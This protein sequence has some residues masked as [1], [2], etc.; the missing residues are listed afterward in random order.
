MPDSD[1]SHPRPASGSWTVAIFALVLAAAGFAVYANSLRGPF[2]FDDLRSIP[3]NPSIHHLVTAFSPPGGGVTVTGRPVLNF[4]FALNYALSGTRVWSYHLFNLLIHLAAGL[5][6]FGIVRRTLEN[7]GWDGTEAATDSGAR[8]R[9]SSVAIAFAAGLLWIVHPLQTESVTYV[10]QRAESLMGLFYLL[11]LYCFIRG[12]RETAGPRTADHTTAGPKGLPLRGQRPRSRVIWYAGSILACLLGMGTKEVMVSAPVMVFLYDRTF[13][14]GSFGQAWR[15]RRGWHLA[16]AA[17]WV[18]L[19]WLVFHAADRGGTAGFGIGIGF[20]QYAATQFEAISRYLW[21]V[22]WPH[23]LIIDYGARWVTSVPDVAPYAAVV[24]VV[25]TLSAM[26][27]WRHPRLGYLGAWFFAILAPTSLVPGARQTIAE[28]RMYLALAP[29]LVLLV[30]AL[31]ALVGRRGRIVFLAAAAGLGALTL[32]RNRTYRHALAL[33]TQTVASR[34]GNPAPHINL[35]NALLAH[36]QPG[37]A[38]IQFET[39]LRLDPQNADAYYDAGNAL[40]QLGRLDEAIGHF[41][42]SLQLHQGS[43]DARNNLADAL[44]QAGRPAEAVKQYESVLRAQPRVAEAHYNLGNALLKAGRTS[45]AAREFEAALRLRPDYP[46]ADNNLGNILARSGR[47]PEAAAHYQAALRADPRNLEAR[48]NLGRALARMGRL[49]EA[50]AQYAAV[51]RL[52]PTAADAAYNLGTLLLRLDRPAEAEVQF[53]TV[54]RLQPGNSA[55]L[56]DLGNILARSGRIDEAVRRFREALR[57]DPSNVP[58]HFN[59]GAAL[60]QSGHPEEARA[61]FEAALRLDPGFAPARQALAGMPAAA[62]GAR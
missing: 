32:Q 13:L 15:R 14:A 53:Q 51:L 62:P 48:E 43:L 55:A 3:E 9:E 59:L 8:R 4:S 17:T 49:N 20:W 30:L 56:D 52:Q 22:V 44:L 42:A 58:A 6:L 12:S 7:C 47:L 41:Q 28:H 18:T 11:T 39:A 10:A 46:E 26:A 29:A 1:P 35:G 60:L 50:A 23:P 2:V 36:R 33:W 19:F 61:E 38:L 37:K 16:L 25:V 24:A 54:L 27:W 34:P 31:H 57:V 21:L 5:V 45:A 40:L